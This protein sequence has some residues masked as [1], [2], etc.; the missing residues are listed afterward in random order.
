MNFPFSL[1]KLSKKKLNFIDLHRQRDSRNSSGVNLAKLINKNIKSVFDHGQYIVG[2]E[3]GQL[4]ERLKNFTGSKHALGVSS[5]TDGLLIALM[6]L[7]IGEND[8]VIT[9]SFSFFATAEV[10]VLLKAK[11]VFV[12]IEP[13]SYNINPKKIEEKINSKTKAI[14]AVSL[15]GQPA[16]FEKINIIANKYS[17]P[18]IED[19]AQSFGSEQNGIKSCNLSSIGVTSFFPSKPLGCYGDGGACFTNSDELAKKIRRISLHGQEKR[20]FHT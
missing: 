6:A 9:T 20:Y 18:V 13:D 5:G 3:V 1:S 12:D 4:E 11:P 19:A 7:G 10:I 17:I 2:P 15:Y 16:N 8:E 14:I